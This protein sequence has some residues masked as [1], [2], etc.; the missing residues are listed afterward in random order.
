MLDALQP[1]D[2]VSA[3][4]AGA[5][6]IVLEEAIGRGIH[7]HV[8]LPIELDEFVKQSV[9]DAGPEWVT[10][11]HV[12]LQHVSTHDECSVVQGDDVPSADWYLAAHDQLLGRAEEVAAGQAIV[13]FTIRPPEGESPPSATDDFASRAHR[14][15]L[16]ELCIDPRPGSSPTVTVN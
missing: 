14:M 2:V 8:V 6:L 9:A 13:A 5:D 16:V 15:G 7:T 11:F 3:A 12:V 1:S 10:R 4:A